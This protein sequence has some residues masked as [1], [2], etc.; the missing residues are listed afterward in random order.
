MK[1]LLKSA[2]LVSLST[3]LLDA[4]IYRQPIQQG[5]ILTNADIQK[6]HTGMRVSQ[7]E[8]ILGEPMLHN[9]YKDNRL[10]YVYTI[11]I[12]RK[13]MA[14]RRVTVLFNN[15]KVTQIQLNGTHS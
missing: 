15:G 7:V 10:V 14:V 11:R 9:I 13:P 12:N 4:C 1:Q 8:Q 2:L 3:L 5:N 6:L